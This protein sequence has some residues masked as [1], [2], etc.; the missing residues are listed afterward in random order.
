[1]VY[2]GLARPPAPKSVA[3]PLDL[4]H[5]HRAA[6]MHAWLQHV[7]LNRYI[8]FRIKAKAMKVKLGY[9]IPQV[10]VRH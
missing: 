7:V 4:T 6:C 3:P 5:S 9:N 10:V 2:L 8:A 1:M